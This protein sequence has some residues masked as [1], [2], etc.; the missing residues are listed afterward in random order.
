MTL[1][2]ACGRYL[3]ARANYSVTGR[4]HAGLKYSEAEDQMLSLFCHG[5]PDHLLADAFTAFSKALIEGSHHLFRGG[6]HE[7]A[8]D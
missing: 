2:E 8:E 6:T 4:W 5:I 7:E 1:D 3:Q